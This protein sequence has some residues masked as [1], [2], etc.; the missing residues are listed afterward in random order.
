MK[1]GNLK[2]LNLNKKAISNFNASINGGHQQPTPTYVV[3]CTIHLTQTS[4]KCDSSFCGTQTNP[5]TIQSQFL[6][7]A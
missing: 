6:S 7:C 2:S 1:K 4:V 3:A 5:G